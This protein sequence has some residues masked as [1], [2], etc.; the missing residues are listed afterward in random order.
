MVQ[1]INQ[2]Y[3]IVVFIGILALVLIVPAK[4]AEAGHRQDQ[5][6]TIVFSTSDSRFYD[7]DDYRHEEHHQKSGRKHK[8]RSKRCRKCKSGHY[9]GHD[10][11]YFGSIHSLPFSAKRIQVDGIT[12]YYSKGTFYRRCAWNGYDIIPAPIGA[13]VM[14]LPL[15]HR[16]RYQYGKMFYHHNGNYYV[17]GRNGYVVV[18]NPEVCRVRYDGRYYDECASRF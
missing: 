4:G 12:Y 8:C 15:G 10:Y 13:T 17:K 14:F 18:E 5:G 16:A 7:D 3:G 2:K 11:L 9:H 6:V 1:H